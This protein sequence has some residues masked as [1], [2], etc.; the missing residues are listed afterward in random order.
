[1]G[2]LPRN[3]SFATDKLILWKYCILIPVFWIN[4]QVLVGDIFLSHFIVR[5]ICVTNLSI[6]TK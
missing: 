4:I 5:Y 6:L 2:L 3:Q 1:M